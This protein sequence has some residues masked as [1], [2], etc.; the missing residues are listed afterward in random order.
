MGAIRD[1]IDIELPFKGGT[2]HSQLLMLDESLGTMA[3]SIG[4][5]IRVKATGLPLGYDLIFFFVFFGKAS[6]YSVY[7]PVYV[8]TN[9]ISLTFTCLPFSPF[10]Q[11]TLS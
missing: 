3:K 11:Y 6:V 10:C 2:T 7:I 5:L 4:G 8:D 9:D 1:I